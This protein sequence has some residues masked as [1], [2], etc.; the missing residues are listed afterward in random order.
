[1]YEQRRWIIGSTH[2]ISL[3]ELKHGFKVAAHVSLDELT[4]IRLLLNVD[5][6]HLVIVKD[7][8]FDRA[9]RE[10]RESA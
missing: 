7:L 1:M 6:K 2:R 9:S 4:H 10:T 8:R 3:E 5:T